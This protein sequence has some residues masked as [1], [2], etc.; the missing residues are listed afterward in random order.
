MNSFVLLRTNIFTKSKN[1]ICA[2]ICVAISNSKKIN[3]SGRIKK[4]SSFIDQQ[5]EWRRK[6]KRNVISTIMEQG[7]VNWLQEFQNTFFKDFVTMYITRGVDFPL[8]DYSWQKIAAFT[9]YLQGYFLKFLYINLIF[10]K[11]TI[12][13]L[14]SVK[15]LVKPLQLK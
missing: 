10:S 3:I 12:F 1:R 8:R 14:W 6:W 9:R 13:F 7:S 5:E 15:I 2:N 4:H 11:A